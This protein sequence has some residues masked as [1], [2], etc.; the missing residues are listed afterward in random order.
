MIFYFS[1]TGNSK[2]IAD[3]IAARTGETLIYMSENSIEKNETYVI[4][5]QE[6]IGFI[7]PVYWYS[8]PTIVEK[9]I[10]QLKLSGYQQQY[11]YAIATFGISAGN[12]MERLIQI[13]DKKQMHLKGLFGVK[14][15]DNY[16][17]GYNIANA[18]KQ[19]N[20]LNTAEAEI[21]KIMAMIDRKENIKYLKR[22]MLAFVTP[23]TGY[24]YRK[25]NHSKKFFVT[26]ACNGCNQCERGCPCNGI[27]M[28]SGKPVWTGNCTFCLKCIHGCKKSAI[29]YGK[30]TE[31]R[32]R[33]QYKEQ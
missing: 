2:H 15:V 26:Q 6:S 20:I 27:H 21:T 14:M 22:G 11:T 10:R 29:Q 8:I 32:D 16:V 17:V 18:E 3:K 5:E 1:G 19:R 31:K 23:L 7:F 25:I 12:V 4:G 13:L 33:Y 30:H 24:A 9:F 28:V